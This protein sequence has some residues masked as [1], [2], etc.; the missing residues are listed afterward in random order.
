MF[1]CSII[2]LALAN[3][4]FEMI[5]YYLLLTPK[6]WLLILPSSCYTFPC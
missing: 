4:T 1:R 3:H 5:P 6:I 2:I